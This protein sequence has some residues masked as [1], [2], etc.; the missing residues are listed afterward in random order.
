MSAGSKQ[1][2]AFYLRL[3]LLISAIWI[4]FLPLTRAGSLPPNFVYLHQVDPT[5][6]Q[7][8]R[9][10][11]SHN[12]IG[13]R[14]KGYHAPTCILTKQAALALAKVQR[15]LRKQSLSLKVYDCYRPQM[16]VNDFVRWSHDPQAKKMKT[17]FYPR[18]PKDK[19]F[20]RG[21]IAKRSGHTRGSTVDLTIVP[22]PYKQPAPY[23][24]SPHAAPCYAPVAQR[25]DDGS[26]DMGTG[27]DCLD[28]L[29]H[30]LTKQV[31]S[32]VYKNRMLLRKLMLKYGFKPFDK[33]WWHFTLANEPYKDHYFNFPIKAP[34]SPKAKKH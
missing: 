9:Y 20:D 28:D 34:G 1:F 24:Y 23:K 17:E 29:S 5:I 16:A 3:I 6:I 4:V 31:S 2:F 8:I 33:E 27:Y 21:Y 22:L 12:F 14:I 26:L 10:Y 15:D 25:Y 32:Q 13:R 19:L 18:E 30:A 11:G 7:D